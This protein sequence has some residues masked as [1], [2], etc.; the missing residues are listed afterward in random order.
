MGSVIEK[1]PGNAKVPAAASVFA[2]SATD[3][4]ISRSTIVDPA[5]SQ[6]TT[7]FDSAVF[8]AEAAI[9][10]H[11]GQSNVLYVSL[12]LNERIFRIPGD[13]LQQLSTHGF[14]GGSVN[15]GTVQIDAE[16]DTD[17][18]EWLVVIALA[19]VCV[20]PVAGAV[21]GV[22]TLVELATD[23]ATGVV[24]PLIVVLAMVGVVVALVI[25]MVVPPVVGGLVVDA[26]E[27]KGLTS[28]P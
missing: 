6:Q 28:H 3:W 10:F 9:V 17:I 24:A 25:G 21:V 5:C 12:I 20:V 27:L 14:A 4:S 11:D 16:V 1:S 8:R 26:L 22:T 7:R 18:V 23:V 15:V 13:P 19:V 2:L